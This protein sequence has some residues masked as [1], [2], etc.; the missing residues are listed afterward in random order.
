M[1]ILN[2]VMKGSFLFEWI[3]AVRNFS[4]HSIYLPMTLFCAAKSK[5]TKEVIERSVTSG[6]H[7]ERQKS[8]KFI[9]AKQQLC[10]C[11]T[12]F[13]TFLSRRFTTATGNIL[14]SRARSMEFVNTEH[15][16]S[17]SKLR[18]GPFGFNPR[19]FCQHLTN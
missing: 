15:K 4:S 14:I 1:S 6:C 7:G 3:T 8:D 2:F 17:F 11:I 16:L 9:L 10:T 18:Y 5:E 19:E 13:C 12:L